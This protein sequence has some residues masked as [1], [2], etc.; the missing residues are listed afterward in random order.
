MEKAD[1]VV[2]SSS[3]H[4]ETRQLP[5]WLSW[6][7]QLDSFGVEAHGIHRYTPEERLEYVNSVN[8]GRLW[9]F[10]HTFGLW[11]AACG[12]LTSMSSFFLSGLVF[13]LNLRDSMVSGIISMNLGCAV[14]AY[15]STMGSQSGCR[16]M[17]GARLLFG[18]WG[19]KVVSLICIVGGVGWSVVNCVLGGQIFA[20]VSGAP[21]SVGIIIIAVLSVIVAV[22]GIKVLVRFQTVL[23]VPIIV[24]VVLFYVV[25]CDKSQ[26]ISHSNAVIKQQKYDS[27]SVRGNWLSFFTIGYSV[28]ASWGSGASDYY[29][30][31]PEDTPLMN[32]YLLT[33]LGLSIPTTLVAVVGTLCGSIA[34][35][36]AP[37]FNAY[38]Q[39]GIG[40]LMNE[41]F[42]KWGR[43][44]QFVMIVWYLSLVCNNIMNTYSAAFEFQLL[45]ERLVYVPRW[46]W[47]FVIAVV[48]FV[49]SIAG[50]QHFATI[51]SNFLPML[52]YWISMYITILAL[53]NI[54]FRR[55]LAT[56][57]RHPKEF[58]EHNDTNPAYIYN[59]NMW[60]ST[61]NITYGFAAM[62]SFVIGAVGA[63]VGMN[64]TYWQ[65][66]I[67]RKIGA[68]GGDIGFWLCMAFTGAVY[69]PLRFLELKKFGK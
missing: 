8:N 38:D 57:R 30:M 9:Q 35:G 27:A 56:R 52:A 29:A 15:F 51:I 10:V 36:Y 69:P 45:D 31:F 54:L 50:K 59:W 41:A 1:S 62:S 4:I 7:Y 3:Y 65:G 34:R 66:P 17:V 47:A 43:F 21:L 64:Q 28:T 26:Y 20:A 37:W 32:V 2:E 33:F 25:V 49:L 68:Y 44:G 42:S 19:V 63:V 24:A 14:A 11:V 61:A 5:R 58:P 23:A 16:Q 48:Y 6:I 40:A 60:N 67:A 39:G 53:E 46:C 55:N 18:V 22:F 12:G 13:E